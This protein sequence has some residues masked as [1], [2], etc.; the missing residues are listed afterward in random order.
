MQYR[1][2]EGDVLDAICWLYY[3][4]K[5]GVVEQVLL[6]NRQLENVGVVMPAGLL[7]ELPDFVEPVKPT[8]QVWD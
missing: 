3:G 6:A 1:T 4:N 7:I 8:V 5:P 2:K